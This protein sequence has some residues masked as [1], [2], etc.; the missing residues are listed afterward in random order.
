MH[1]QRWRYWRW[2]PRGA[3]YGFM[4]AIFV[5][6]VMGY[7]FWKTDVSNIYTAET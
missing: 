2:T 4:Y 7:Y 6:G 3:L 1:K 5:P